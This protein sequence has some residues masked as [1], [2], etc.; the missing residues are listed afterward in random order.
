MKAAYAEHPGRILVQAGAGAVALLTGPRQFFPALRRRKHLH[1][2][3]DFIYFSAVFA[4]GV[5]GLHTAAIAFGG[6]VA[7]VGF[8]SLAMVWLW[9]SAAAMLSARRGDYATHE[10]WAL[11]SFA[12]TNSSRSGRSVGCPKQSCGG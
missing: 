7:R 4:S 3:L 2:T 8:G 9:S 1:R 5:A 12:L 10:A 6:L 11:R